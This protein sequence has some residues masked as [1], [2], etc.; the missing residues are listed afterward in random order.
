MSLGNLAE[1]EL[2]IGQVSARL[3]EIVSAKEVIAQTI[4]EFQEAQKIIGNISF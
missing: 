1:G 4:S 3:K 2:E